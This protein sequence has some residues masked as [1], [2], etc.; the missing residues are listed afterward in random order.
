[1]RLTKMTSYAL[2]IL[3]HCGQTPERKVRASDIANAYQITEANVSKVVQLLVRAGLLETVRGPGGGLMLARPPRE[4]RIGDIVRATEDTT[5][6]TDCFGQGVDECAILHAVP[7][8]RVFG[9]AVDA[10]IE[11]LDRHS[12]EEFIRL[13]NSPA[14]L[15]QMTALEAITEDEDDRTPAAVTARPASKEARAF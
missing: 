12:L 4:I 6:Q 2:R 14:L 7:I 3:I 8:N 1:M 11:V 15:A 10:F 9:N 13:R 5:I